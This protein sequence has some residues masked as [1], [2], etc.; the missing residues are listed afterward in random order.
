MAWISQ[1]QFFL[2]LAGE[3]AEADKFGIEGTVTYQTQIRGKLTYEPNVA[4]KLACE[5]NID[6]LLE[7]GPP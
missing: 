7:V 1:M 4:G 3:E 5:P 6:G 2:G